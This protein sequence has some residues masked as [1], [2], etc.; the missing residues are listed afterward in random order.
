LVE[1]HKK[2]IQSIHEQRIRA[3]RMAGGASSRGHASPLAET[4][5]TELPAPADVQ[6][7][8][9][10]SPT[11]ETDDGNTSLEEEDVTSLREK[12]AALGESVQIERTFAKRE[13]QARR[14]NRESGLEGSV[15]E[16]NGTV[17]GSGVGPASMGVSVLARNEML[18]GY[19]RQ[20]G[21]SDSEKV[22]RG[23]TPKRD[24]F[25]RPVSECISLI[26]L[27]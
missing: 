1:A 5:P 22:R 2:A 11:P 9:G 10:S 12:L 18:D 25:G 4:A 19:L 21:P 3:R 6:D 15:E 24:V 14:W 17:T 8:N 16:S 13:Q 7:T 20:G 23:A 27:D 26:G